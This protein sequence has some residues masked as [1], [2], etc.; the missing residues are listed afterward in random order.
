MA[1]KEMPLLAARLREAGKHLT[2]ETAG[3][4]PPAGI[5]CDLASISPKLANSTPAEGSIAEEWIGSVTSGR[6]FS[7]KLIREWISAYPFQ[8]KFVVETGR[9]DLAGNPGDRGV[10]W[11]SSDPAVEG[12][13]D[14]TR[15]R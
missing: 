2:I 4:L 12:S 5:A 15:D 1:A 6:A 9:R 3:T 14:A 8:L 13:A 7:R 11:A 10:R